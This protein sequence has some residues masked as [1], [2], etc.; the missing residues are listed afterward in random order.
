MKI[1][2]VNVLPLL[3]GRPALIFICTR[4]RTRV[5]TRVPWYL[6]TREMSDEDTDGSYR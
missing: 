6:G 5:R 1:K 3:F 2:G 4:G